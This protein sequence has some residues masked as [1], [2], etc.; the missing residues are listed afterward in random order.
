MPV[1]IRW[2]S[3]R[4]EFDIP[5]PNTTLGAIRTSIAQYLHLEPH[6]F[7]LVHDGAVMADDNATSTSSIR[8]IAFIAS[9]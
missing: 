7:H 1:T 8:P 6:A 5:A 2:G 3:D 4:F 9:R